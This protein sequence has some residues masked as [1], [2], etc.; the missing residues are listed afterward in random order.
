VFH[1]R[2]NRVFRSRHHGAGAGRP[3]R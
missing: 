1:R 2:G 3:W